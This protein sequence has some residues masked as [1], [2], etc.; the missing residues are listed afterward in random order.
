MGNVIVRNV[1]SDGR[2]Q[3]GTYFENAATNEA[4]GDLGGILEAGERKTQQRH[5]ESTD[6]QE[7]LAKK[8]AKEQKA[9]ADRQNQANSGF[10]ANAFG[11]IEKMSNIALRSYRQEVDLK[12]DIG[13]ALGALG[14]V[15][16][17][18]TSGILGLVGAIPGV[19]A[20]MGLLAKGA[21]KAA[22]A[23]SKITPNKMLGELDAISAGFGKVVKGIGGFI[24]GGAEELV[25]YH[26]TFRQISNSGAAFSGDLLE[27]KAAAGMARL[28]ID[29]LSNIFRNGGED[30]AGFGLDV[31]A[32][33]KQLA[34]N[35]DE[36]ANNLEPTYHS[37]KQLGLTTED[38]NKQ[39]MR[40][41]R[42]D[43]RK[44]WED[45][46]V[47]EQEQ[48]AEARF[49]KELDLMSRLTGKQR[50]EIQAQIDKQRRQAEVEATIQ[51]LD[52]NGA[53]GVGDAFDQA[54][55]TVQQFGPGA[56]DAFKE[57]FAQGT[58]YSEDGMK[59]FTAM[60]SAGDELMKLAL[61]VRQGGDVSDFSADLGGAMVERIRQD[62][63]LS[64][65]KLGA[66]GSD[67]GEKAG[68]ML[69][70][71]LAL[72][73]AIYKIQQEFPEL[74]PQEAYKK[75]LK[76]VADAQK[77]QAEETDT[78]GKSLNKLFN[79]LEDG[80]ENAG[81]ALNQRMVVAV[82]NVSGSMIGLEGTL[83]GAIT[84]IAD[85]A[86][87][88]G[89]G[90]AEFVRPDTRVFE[91]LT[92][93]QKEALIAGQ[94]EALKDYQ[95]KMNLQ[96]QADNMNA[97][98]ASQSQAL[99]GLQDQA[100]EEKKLTTQIKSD[101]E[102]VT[103]KLTKFTD[104]AFAKIGVD[105]A[106]IRKDMKT[107]MGNWKED[108]RQWLL[109]AGIDVDKIWSR[110]ETYIV[111]PLKWLGEVMS[112]VAKAILTWIGID[113]DKLGAKIGE[114]LDWANIKAGSLYEDG[115]EAIGTLVDAAIGEDE[116][117]QQ[118]A[119]AVE[120]NL[121][122]IP[123]KVY[124]ATKNG[125]AAG[126]GYL[127]Q[128]FNN[129]VE[130]SSTAATPPQLPEIKEEVPVSITSVAPTVPTL[131]T[132]ITKQATEETKSESKKLSEKEQQ[133]QFEFEQLFEET[134]AT[135][136]SL[137]TFVQQQ[138]NILE[139]LKKLNTTTEHGN[140]I[141]DY[142]ARQQTQTNNKLGGLKSNRNDIHAVLQ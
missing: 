3:D 102:I 107:A 84:G 63:F 94:E 112:D 23:L 62:D 2:L 95:K 123:G 124:D 22:G 81:S 19:G 11:A 24:Q 76:D 113:V 58:V 47:R 14:S 129:L 34:L 106:A 30:L 111:E 10:F 12:K 109:E 142:Q 36:F 42:F 61:R 137:N 54:M 68:E 93:E 52:M 125:I 78:T 119:D 121:G 35:M 41:M 114:G 131:S 26:K 70:N 38:I 33:V 49:S 127:Q 136:T 65:A 73:D 28:S 56:V 100:K 85:K 128:G 97:A 138:Y 139:E 6:Q 90:L 27:M 20:G 108:S 69:T 122:E 96:K 25:S 87:E 89:L 130:G 59:A 141:S 8:N 32:G 117:Q 9:L 5:Q 91:S 80:L 103:D 48:L 133:A 101:L 88:A 66:V 17:A 44:N 104:D 46:E 43:R 132:A 37:L 140:S 16:K 21:G 64:L 72:G 82:N 31:S 77:K 105:S 13:D 75:A 50:E 60:G 98:F 99:K 118:I 15:A 83:G 110:I 79:S 71:G 92:S 1:D 4:I 55:Q 135:N 40:Q 45:S 18:A 53:K 39:M 7:D 51:Q 116:A 29:Q 115:K 134:K 57:I 67:I 126:W 74:T 86:R 120:E